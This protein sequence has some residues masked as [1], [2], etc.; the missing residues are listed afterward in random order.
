[1]ERSDILKNAYNEFWRKVLNSDE[2]FYSKM[3]LGDFVEL[4][5]AISNI[6]NIITLQV[7]NN[8]V[9]FLKEKGLVSKNQ[10]G[11]IKRIVESTNAN[12]NGFDIEYPSQSSKDDA[13]VYAEGEQKI[14]A[15]V[16][17]CIPVNKNSYGGAQEES[18][19][20]DID[21]LLNGKSKSNIN[22]EELK[23]NYLKFLVLLGGHNEDEREKV[24]TSAEKLIT[25]AKQQGWNV[26]LYDSQEN[27]DCSKV[28]VVIL[29][30]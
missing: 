28:Y 21:G 8:F 19:I 7:T 5:K 3:S 10:A 22:Q 20:D 24:K 6:N 13:I 25:K 14:I 9:D 11:K 18:I 23:N 1:M 2:D 29:N 12:T 16:K 30:Y 26:E 17:C 4:K 15:E 27:L